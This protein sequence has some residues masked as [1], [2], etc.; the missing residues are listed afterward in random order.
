MKMTK[1]L[2][3][4]LLLITACRTKEIFDKEIG[5]MITGEQSLSETIQEIGHAFET[6]E[7]EAPS[8]LVARFMHDR[9]STKLFKYFSNR[10]SYKDIEGLIYMLLDRMMQEIEVV[11]SDRNKILNVLNMLSTRLSF[12]NNR[13]S[14][15]S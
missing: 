14:R 13:Q 10:Y 15:P 2:L 7:E 1:I 11:L 9:L 3:T 5:K 8:D 4:I 12:C 6:F